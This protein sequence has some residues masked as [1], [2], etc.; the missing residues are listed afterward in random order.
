MEEVGLDEDVVFYCSGVRCPRSSAGATRA[1]AWGYKKIY[2][3]REG[4]PA[5]KN[6]GYPVE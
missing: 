2:Y 4:F 3:F 5:W 6:A 1:V